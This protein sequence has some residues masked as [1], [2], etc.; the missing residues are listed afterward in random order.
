MGYGKCRQDVLY[1][2]FC[3]PLEAGI[4]RGNLSLLAKAIIRGK[5][6]ESARGSRLST[7]HEVVRFCPTD[8][9]FTIGVPIQASKV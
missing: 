9:L 3:I 1:R 6:K 8:L 5:R 4:R 2:D 7:P